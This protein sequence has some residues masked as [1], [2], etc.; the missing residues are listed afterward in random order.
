MQSAYLYIMDALRDDH[1]NAAMTPNLQALAEDG[2]RF[3]QAIAQATWSHPSMMAMM[4]GLYPT[5]VGKFGA[6]PD[7]IKPPRVGFPTSVETLATLF[8]KNG[9][10]TAAYSANNFFAPTFG[11]DRGFD[12]MPLVYDLPEMAERLS[13]NTIVAERL[14]RKKA[15]LQPFPIVTSQDLHR[16][17]RQ[18]RETIEASALLTVIWSMD[19]HDPFYDRAQVDSLADEATILI[20]RSRDNPDQAHLLY[21][22]MVRYTDQHFGEFIEELKARGEYDDAFIVICADHGESFG[23]T[24]RFGHTGFAFEEQIRIPLI[25]KLPGNAYAGHTVDEQIG[26]IDILPTLAGWYGIKLPYEVHGKDLLPIIQ[27]IA[28]GHDYM[29]CYDET[30]DRYYIHGCVRTRMQKYLFR[31][32]KH[33]EVAY[34]GRTRRA[35]YTVKKSLKAMQAVI[36]RDKLLTPQPI[37]FEDWAYDLQ[38][39]P[40]EQQNIIETADFFVDRAKEQFEVVRHNAL[41][42]FEAHVGHVRTVHIADKV[43]QRLRDL[44][45]LE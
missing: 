33:P 27:G 16:I 29:V 37:M 34:E 28:N 22:S 5:A 32:M 15:P 39:D 43:E 19:T 6:L 9:W 21:E 36:Q 42:F 40:T 30:L 14:G 41:Q 10:Y 1:V 26:L 2:V 12:S 13:L 7:E 31:F 35:K 20:R 25:I 17:R 44:G 4:A 24:E 18:Q 23:E 3:S 38:N 8:Q 45:Y 11:M